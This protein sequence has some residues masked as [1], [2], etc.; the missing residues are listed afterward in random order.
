M[1]GIG[2]TSISAAGTVGPAGTPV[3]VNIWRAPA[4]NEL[5]EVPGAILSQST[6]RPAN[7]GD[8]S[9]GVS[10]TSNGVISTLSAAASAT[11]PNS[12]VTSSPPPQR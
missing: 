5:S 3:T 11:G 8:G 12:V 6:G 9:E 7:R 10:G 2:V 1:Y 4:A